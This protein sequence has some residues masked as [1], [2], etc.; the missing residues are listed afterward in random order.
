MTNR[1]MLT[2]VINGAVTA[3]V[4]AKAQECLTAL[5]KRNENRK[6]KPSK[7][8]VENEPV[9]TAILAFVTDHPKAFSVDVANAVGITTQ[10]MTSLGVRM[11]ADGVLTKEKVKVKGKG[12]QTVWSVPTED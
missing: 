10:K 11:V 2:A 6:S 9:R 1:E 4:I 7:R 3:E 8:T 5:D 12:E